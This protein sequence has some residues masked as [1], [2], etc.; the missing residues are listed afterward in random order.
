VRL[1]VT[2]LTC[3]EP[4]ARPGSDQNLELSLIRCKSIRALPE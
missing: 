3:L 1:I 4:Y 2:E